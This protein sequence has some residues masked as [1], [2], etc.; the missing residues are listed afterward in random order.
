MTAAQLDALSAVHASSVILTT[1]GAVSLTGTAPAFYTLSAA[2]N[3]LDLSG[4]TTTGAFSIT[5][6]AGFDSMIGRNL[7]GHTD[8][9]LGNDGDDVLN[10]LAG[11]DWL[12]GGAGADT[13]SGG[14]G[15]GV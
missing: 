8:Y 3:A 10:G 1:G 11:D 13:M 4:V 12:D 14:D 15:A 9:L 2:G 6:G 5:G 7:A